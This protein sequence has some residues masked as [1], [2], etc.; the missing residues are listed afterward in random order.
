MAYNHDFETALVRKGWDSSAEE[1]KPIPKEGFDYIPMAVADMGFIVCPAIVESMK[2]RLEHPIFGYNSGMDKWNKVVL[3]WQKYRFGV[4]L[5]EANIGYEHGVHGGNIT[6]LRLFAKPGDRIL[7]HTPAYGSFIRN[8]KNLGYVMVDSPL[9]IDENNVWRM[10]FEDMEKKIVAEDITTL[11]FCSPH[12]PTGRVWEK[13]ELEKM[14]ELCEKYHVKIVSDEIWSDFIFEGKVHTPTQLINDYAKY[15]TI[16]LYAPSK[17]FNLAGLVGSY[18]VIYDPW[19]KNRMIKDENLHMY[20]KINLLS[21]YAFLGAYSDEG[22]AWK[23]KLVETIETNSKF[24][25]NYIREKF[26]GVEVCDADGTYVIF[27]DTAKWQEKHGKTQD[28]LLN[29]AYEYGVGWQ[30]GR[31]F[32][33]MTH[34]RI[35]LAQPTWRVKEAFDRLDKYVFNAEW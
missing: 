29:K 13:W 31:G 5:T 33:G 23:D 4:D 16:A 34:F 3:E 14:V 28:E 7:L 8:L 6:A 25:V 21:L 24:A 27:I 18:H 35:N 19:L 32:L 12:N 2:G 1:N 22:K 26:E 15:N 30:D 11:L 17:T 9:K 10:D 20:N